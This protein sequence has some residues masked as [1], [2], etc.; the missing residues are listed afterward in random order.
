ML[1]EPDV[2]ES[3]LLWSAGLAFVGMLASQ[4]IAKRADVSWLDI[5]KFWPLVLLFPA[6]YL[7][8]RHKHIPARFGMVAMALF[9]AAWLAGWWS[10]NGQ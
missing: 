1:R 8:G 2:T 6:D 10:N 3:I 9:A 5:L 7:D 4:L